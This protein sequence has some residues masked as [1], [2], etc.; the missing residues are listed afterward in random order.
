MIRRRDFITLLGGAAVTWPLA[1]R[2]QQVDRVRRIG[3]LTALADDAFTQARVKALLQGLQ[4]LGWVEGSNIRLDYRFAAGDPSLVPAYMTELAGLAP[5]LIV[6]VNSPVVAALK[7]A[8]SS[9]P[10]VFVAIADPVE[11]GFVASLARPGGN[12]T[13][14]ITFEAV[15]IGKMLEMLKEMA[16]GLAR[17]TVMFNPATGAFIPAYLRSF[18][19]VGLSFGVTAA[20]VFIREVSE[21]EGTIAKLGREPGSGLIV[22]PEAF[23]NTHRESIIR[24]A[25]QH[26]VPA[27]YGYRSLVAEGGLMSFGADQYDIFRRSA[28]YVDRI[29]K[30]E[31]P[32]DLPVQ[33]PVKYEIAINLKTAKTLGLTVPLALLTRADEVIE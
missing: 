25:E 4:E 12:I 10:I 23:T 26:R 2:A 5:D 8:T 1:A 28:S 7:Q 31:R 15:L 29:L 19:A 6:A 16:P 20:P 24:S 33:R 17:A 9:I 13:G 22:P 27:I 11:Q 3:F 18:E 21:I 32:A 14:F 30:G